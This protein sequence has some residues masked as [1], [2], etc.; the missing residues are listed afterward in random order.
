MI[1][2]SHDLGYYLD[3]R[4]SVA[5]CKRC[6]AEGEKLAEDCPQKLI[7]DKKIDLG[8]PPNENDNYCGGY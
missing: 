8:E 1:T 7:P 5:Y 6:S 4:V 2:K 3:G